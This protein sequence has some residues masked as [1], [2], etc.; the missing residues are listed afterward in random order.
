M[1]CIAFLL[2]LIPASTLFAKVGLDLSAIPQVKSDGSVDFLKSERRKICQDR[3]GNAAFQKGMD[4]GVEG[5]TRA[6]YPPAT[7]GRLSRVVWNRIRHQ[8][9]SDAIV[10]RA[11]LDRMRKCYAAKRLTITDTFCPPKPKLLD[12]QRCT[13]FSRAWFGT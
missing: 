11:R 3:F 12:R 4:D 6:C 13:V 2:K 10:L 8:L 1:P 5:N 7:F 9:T